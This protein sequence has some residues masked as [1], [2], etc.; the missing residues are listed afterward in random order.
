[1]PRRLCPVSIAVRAMGQL[2]LPS[3][4]IRATRYG[5]G[6]KRLNESSSGST[7]GSPSMMSDNREEEDRSH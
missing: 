6:R 4:M 7:A 3:T 1:M 5:K 2:S